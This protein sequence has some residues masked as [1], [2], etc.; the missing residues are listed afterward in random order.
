M[1]KDNSKTTKKKLSGFLILHFAIFILSLASLCSKSASAHDFLSPGFILLYGGV[2][3]ALFVYA[4]IWQQ[5]LK[6]MPLVIAFANKVATLFWSFIYGV[7][8]FGEGVRPNMI[9]GMLVVVAGVLLV[10]SGDKQ[11]KEESDE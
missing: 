11:K 9:I 7:L 2:V 8:I 1:K 6:R 10:I 4:I 5:V 3:V